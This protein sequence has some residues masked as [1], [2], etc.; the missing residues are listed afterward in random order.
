MGCSDRKQI[1]RYSVCGW[2]RTIGAIRHTSLAGKHHKPLGHAN[3]ISQWA[4]E[5]S[6][7]RCFCV[8]DLQSAAFAARLPARGWLTGFKTHISLLLHFHALTL[9]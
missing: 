4:G 8:A 2:I 9:I 5:D 3:K 6:N 7:L 1:L